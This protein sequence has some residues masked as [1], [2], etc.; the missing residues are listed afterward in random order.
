MVV[1][2]VWN[3]GVFSPFGKCMKTGAFLE[4]RT[5]DR[6]I[7]IRYPTEWLEAAAVDIWTIPGN[8]FRETPSKTTHAVFFAVKISKKNDY[9]SHVFQDAL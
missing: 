7:F 4:I 9:S 1:F 2:E 8:V 6:S 3:G 5:W